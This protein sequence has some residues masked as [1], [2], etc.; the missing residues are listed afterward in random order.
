MVEPAT[1]EPALRWRARY[2]MAS[3]LLSIVLWLPVTVT[4]GGYFWSLNRS[5]RE[6]MVSASAALALTVLGLVIALPW[7]TQRPRPPHHPR[8]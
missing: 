6:L 7:R 4:P 5:M 8:S 3:G 2:V 1:V